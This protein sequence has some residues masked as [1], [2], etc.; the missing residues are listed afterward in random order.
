MLTPVTL[1]MIHI[2]WEFRVRPGSEAEFEEHYSAQGTWAQ[3]FRQ[4]PAYHG[5]QLLRDAED[6]RRYVTIDAWDD[7]SSYGAFRATYREQYNAIDQQMESLTESE[8]RIGVFQ[9]LP[10]A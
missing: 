10:V 7:E 4:D 1:G 9:V 5:T 6:P 3:F 2:I 8:K